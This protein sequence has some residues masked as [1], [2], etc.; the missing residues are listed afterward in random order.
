MTV[1][2]VVNGCLALP[3]V[4]V[5]ACIV[6]GCTLDALCSQLGSAVCAFGTP[7]TAVSCSMGIANAALVLHQERET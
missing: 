6:A 2:A 4:A 7:V 1:L 3:V 5:S